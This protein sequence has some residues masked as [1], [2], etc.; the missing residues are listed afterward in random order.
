MSKSVGKLDFNKLKAIC[1]IKKLVTIINL[2]SQQ[3]KKYPVEKAKNEDW[4]NNEIT[5]KIKEKK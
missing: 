3:I 2:F 1:G 5:A 4:S